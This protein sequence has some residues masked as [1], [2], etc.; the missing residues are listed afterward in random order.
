MFRILKVNVTHKTFTMASTI[1]SNLKK[2]KHKVTQH[3]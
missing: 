1:D 3:N 2:K